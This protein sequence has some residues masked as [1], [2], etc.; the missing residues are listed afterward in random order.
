MSFKAKVAIA[1]V[2]EQET[3]AQLS[4]RYSVHS[5]QIHQ[6]KR[7]LLEGAEGVFGTVG[8]PRKGDPDEVS[9]D[10][11]YEQIGRLKMELELLSSGMTIPE[12]LEDY[13]DLEKED[14][15]A[16]LAWAARLAQSRRLQS[17]NP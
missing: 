7:Q 12:I 17:V 14:L 13:E 15:L 5:S 9:V 1:A 3:V 11:L 2:R 16:A 10:E 8:R 6:W 4:S